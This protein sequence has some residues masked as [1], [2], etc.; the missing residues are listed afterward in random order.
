MY[1]LDMNNNMAI[2]RQARRVREV[3]AYGSGQA[4]TGWTADEQGAVSG[5]GV[6]ATLAL[7][8]AAPMVLLAW[9]LMVR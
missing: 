5:A 7:A 8:A 3:R 6:K 4:A 2:E 9:G 1:Q